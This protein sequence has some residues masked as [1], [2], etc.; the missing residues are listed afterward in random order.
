MNTIII[1]KF[2]NNLRHFERQLEMQNASGCCCGVSLTQCHLLMELNKEDGITVN[3]LSARLVLDKSTISRT[4]EGLVNMG[5]VNMII[6]KE[7]RRT[8]HIYLTDEGNRV[9]AT[10]NSGNDDYFFKAMSAIPEKDRE[11][12]FSSFEKLVNKMLKQNNK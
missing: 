5:M 11:V 7:N 12:F 8:T 9:C 4:V 2:R 1:R 6:P 3:T 10:I